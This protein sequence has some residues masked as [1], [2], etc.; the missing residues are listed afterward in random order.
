LQQATREHIEVAT[1]INDILDTAIEE[2][3]TDL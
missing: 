2:V 1:V 3:E